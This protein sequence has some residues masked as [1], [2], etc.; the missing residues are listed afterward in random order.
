MWTSQNRARYDRSKLRTPLSGLVRGIVQLLAQHP[1]DKLQIV[2]Y[3]MLQLFGQN[4]LLVQQPILVFDQHLHPRDGILQSYRPRRG[5]DGFSQDIGEAG[6]E[7]D[8]VLIVI[9]LSV[10]VDLQ[11]TIGRGIVLGVDDDVDGRDDTM[12]GVEARQLEIVVLA[13]IIADRWLPRDE[14]TALWRA[15]IGVFDRTDDSRL[16]AVSCFDEKVVLRGTVAAHLG[17]WHV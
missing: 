1:A 7:I 13:Y 3:P 5:S 9:V 12:R 16:P 10:V 4:F 2:A 8:I 11:H 6:K 15:G 17:E 14:R